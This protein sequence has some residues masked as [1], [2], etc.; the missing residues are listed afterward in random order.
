VT[1]P[2]PEQSEHERGDEHDSDSDARHGEI[3]ACLRDSTRSRLRNI[4]PFVDRG[5]S[6]A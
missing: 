2:P 4:E 6:S 5:G 3:N 1:A